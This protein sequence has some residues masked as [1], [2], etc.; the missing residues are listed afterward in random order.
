[1]SKIPRQRGFSMIEVMV[2][3]AIIVVMLATAVPS[4]AEWL[5]NTKVRNATEAIQR[6][7]QRA[8]AES[9]RR[10]ANVTFWLVSLTDER[11]MD[12]SCA[13]SST[14]GSWVISLSDPAGKCSTSPSTTVDPYI[15][16]SHAA[17]DG[18]GGV[19]VLAKTVNGASSAQCV[20][21]NG[22][23][24]VVGSTVPPD[25]SCRSPGQIGAIYVSNAGGG[26][27]SLRIVVSANGGVRMCVEGVAAGDPRACP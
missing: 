2:T 25:D 8:R 27:R 17:G 1:M 18:G 20:R 23:G 26:A 15:I 5:R 9:L 16:E 19:T 7:L 13:K 21:F 14:A 3:L 11:T 10:N 6:G 22:F 4:M 24:Q 12:D